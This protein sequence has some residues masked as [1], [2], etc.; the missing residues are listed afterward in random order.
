MDRGAW[1]AAVHGSQRVRHE[2]AHGADVYPP[3]APG[4]WP[5]LVSV[6]SLPRPPAV[7]ARPSQRPPPPRF[8]TLQSAL[9]L[10]H[11]ASLVSEPPPRGHVGLAL[12]GP[13]GPP[14]ALRGHRPRDAPG[15]VGSCGPAQPCAWTFEGSSQTQT[16]LQGPAGDGQGVG[17]PQL[18]AQ[19]S[20]GTPETFG[21]QSLKGEPGALP[22]GP[23]G[24]DEAGCDCCGVLASQVSGTD[25]PTHQGLTAADVRPL[26]GR[27]AWQPPRVFLLENPMDRRVWGAPVC[28]VAELDRTGATEPAHV[29]SRAGGQSLESG[30]HGAASSFFCLRPLCGLWALGAQSGLEPRA[31]ALGAQSLNPWTPGGSPNNAVCLVFWPRTER[32]VGSQFSN[33]PR[34]CS[35]WRLF[36]P[37]RPPAA[38][39]FPGWGM[40]HRSP[41]L[42]HHGDVFPVCLRPLFPSLIRT[43]RLRLHLGCICKDPVSQQSRAHRSPGVRT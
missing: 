40:Q 33:G 21:E 27:R 38:P 12:A 13:A 43:P 30:A 34:P 37:P 24:G 20:L 35:F 28:R 25:P 6:P 3:S 18:M 36:Q 14:L 22:T 15:S 39:A 11:A 19:V 4:L 32:P 26:T 5:G 9:C 1:W 41:G 2:C 29:V 42:G 17:A 23:R 8:L 10:L 7:K 16:C 31:T